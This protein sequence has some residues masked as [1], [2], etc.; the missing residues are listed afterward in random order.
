MYVN[1]LKARNKLDKVIRH[2]PYLAISEAKLQLLTSIT[3]SNI[4][5][6]HVAL[7]YL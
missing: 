4:F 5:S 2:Q 7:L 3:F 1:N 6:I